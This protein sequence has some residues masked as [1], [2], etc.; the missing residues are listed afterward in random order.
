MKSGKQRAD[1]VIILGEDFQSYVVLEGSE[2]RGHDAED[3]IL[4]YE[5]D[6]GTHFHTYLKLL[7]RTP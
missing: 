7:K 4:Q 3:E 5:C 2:V 6:H 1:N